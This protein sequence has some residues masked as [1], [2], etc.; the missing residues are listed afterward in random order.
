M[1]DR[2][3][4]EAS[5]TSLQAKQSNSEVNNNTLAAKVTYEDPTGGERDG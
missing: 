2:P 4:V 3:S 1:K 5:R